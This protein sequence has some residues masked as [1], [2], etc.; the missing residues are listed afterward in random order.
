MPNNSFALVSTVDSMPEGFP[1]HCVIIFSTEQ[2]AVKYAVDCIAKHDQSV[3]YYVEDNL[4]TTGHDTWNDA[5]EF[6]EAWQEALDITE[7]FHVK[8]VEEAV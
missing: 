8:P 1:S 6:L 3:E 7:Y 5:Q 2:E 4:W